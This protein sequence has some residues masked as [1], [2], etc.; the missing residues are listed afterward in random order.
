LTTRGLPADID[1]DRPRRPDALDFAFLQDAQHLR[2]RRGRHVPNLVEEDRAAVGL[3]ELARLFA[4]GAGERAAFVAEELGLDE[5]VRDRGAVHLHERAGLHERALVD[6]AR[7]ELLARSARPH[8]EDRRGRRRGLRDV[9]K[10]PADRL[11]VP[12]EPG[13]AE[14]RLQLEVLAHEAPRI[15]DPSK[16]VQDVLGR[17]RLLEEIVGP[18][19]HGLHGCLHVAMARDDDD[20][21]RDA[22]PAHLRERLEAVLAGHLDV[23]EHRVVVRRLGEGVHP[24]RDRRHVIPLVREERS[25]RVANVRFVVADE[26]ASGHRGDPSSPKR[27]RK[28][29]PSVPPRRREVRT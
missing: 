21:R 18:G 10:E 17:E 12:D 20:G 11:A 24:R 1:F 26:D 6:R 25:K 23:E 28:R 4:V 9:G 7:H 29:S 22:A 8:D 5:A 27:A 19:V 13:D 2:L 14:P 16:R 3:H 15:E